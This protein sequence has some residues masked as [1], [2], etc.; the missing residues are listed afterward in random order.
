[1]LTLDALTLV[2]HV[3]RK[4]YTAKLYAHGTIVW[5]VNTGWSREPHGVRQRL[6]KAH[7]RVLVSAV[8]AGSRR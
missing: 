8:L 6:P 1:M 5:L 3:Q 4:G 2:A 7:T